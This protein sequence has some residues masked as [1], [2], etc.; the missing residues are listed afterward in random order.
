M[1]RVIPFLILMMGIFGC[2]D[3]GATDGPVYDRSA[4]LTNW[5]DNIIIPAYTAFSTELTA[6]KTAGT[7]FTTTP[8][9]G[10]LA[11]LRT[12]W[13]DAYIAWQAVSMFEIGK[14]EE[15]LYRNNMNIYPVNTTEVEDNIASG[16]YNLE[17]P[18]LYDAQGFPALDYLI[19]GLAAT[20]ADIVGFYTTNGNAENYKTYLTDVITRMEDLTDQVLTDWTSGYRDTFVSNSG[21]SA[22]ASTDKY[23]NDYIFYYE[24]ALRAGKVGIP[25]GNFSGSTLPENVEAFYKKDISKELLLAAIDASKNFFEGK[26]FNSNTTGES[27]KSYLEF[28][29]TNVDGAS[30]SSQ[31]SDQ[32]DTARAKAAT[33]NDNF[34]E[35]IN[36][37]NTLMLETFDEL[38]KNVVFLKTD[39][40][41]AMSI[42]VDFVDADGD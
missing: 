25:A 10:N 27:L 35:Q 7:T 41:S 26:H 5:A 29:N 8:T 17:L 24:K 33:L 14:A 42:N 32:F 28:L 37:N 9:E 19:N 18:S 21:S 1:K 34:V 4:M 30:L 36:S 6:L 12:E 3:D 15:L 22:T 23:V 20:D 2:S 11:T 31:I 40:L 38:Q 39:M 16:T 13:K